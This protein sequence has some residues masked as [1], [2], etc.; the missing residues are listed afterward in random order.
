MVDRSDQRPPSVDRV[1]CSADGAGL[2]ARASPAPGWLAR[3]E[4][5]PV[6]VVHPTADP[7]EFARLDR[8]G[9]PPEGVLAVDCSAENVPYGV[10]ASGGRLRLFRF[11]SAAGTRATTTSF[12][13][14]DTDALRP[15][16]RPLL[17]LLGPASLH[18][19][20]HFARLVD[21]ARRFGS[22]LRD[23]LD[24]ELRLRVLRQLARG[25]G[26]WAESEG[27]SLA[28]PSTRQELEHACL[29][30]VFRALFVL[31]AESSGYLPLD[32]AGYGA[33]A[34]TTL[35]TEQRW[36]WLSHRWTPAAV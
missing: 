4:G 17:G 15:E 24:D 6:L 26:A 32:R 16:D 18:R 14:L 33:N 9:R 11:A 12:L 31:Y 23:R 35:A 20:G 1:A 25:L 2:R 19:D 21:D 34:A 3:R 28:D 36:G 30:W 5:S 8:D 27:H 13:E 10:L 7:A 29:A 22:A